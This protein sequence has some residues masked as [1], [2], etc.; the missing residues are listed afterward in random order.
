MN[1]P[2]M[3]TNC[4]TE[5]TLAAF[6]DGRLDGKARRRVV[7]HVA[8]CGECRDVILAAGELRVFEAPS[9]VIFAWRRTGKVGAVAALAAAAVLVVL[10]GPL[11]RER[12]FPT[13][14]VDELVAAA[15]ELDFRPLEG[16]MSGEVAYK[17]YKAPTRGN[18]KHQDQWSLEAVAGR[19]RLREEHHKNVETIRAVGVAH[20]L[21]KEHDDA[22]QKLEEALHEATHERITLVAIR[23]TDNWQLLNDLGVAYMER[24]AFRG[25]AR[26]RLA[27]IEILERA[28]RL[29][30]G[31]EIA[32]N[33]ALALERAGFHDR[34][35]AAWNEYLRLDPASQWSVDAK[36]HIQNLTESSS[37]RYSRDELLI[38]IR[39]AVRKR[40]RNQLQSLADLYPEQFR[41]ISEEVLI[42]EAAALLPL[43][44]DAL[45][46]A[47]DTAAVLDQRGESLPAD[48]LKCL[49]RAGAESIRTG[50]RALEEYRQGRERMQRGE[51]ATAYEL[52]NGATEHLLEVRNPFAVRAAVFR[53][54]VRLYDGHGREA[55]ALTERALQTPQL[56]RWPLAAAQLYWVRGL[57]LHGAGDPG[58]AIRSY[59]E[60]SRLI[61]QTA[62]KGSR[63]GIE[64]VLADALRDVG[65]SDE[66]WRHHM[67]AVAALDQTV[68]LERKQNVLNGFV[69]AAAREGYRFLP[70]LVHEDVVSLARRVGDPLFLCSSQL[71]GAQLA[72]EMLDIPA[73]E[74][75]L[76]EAQMA[77]DR[78][79]ESGMRK[80]LLADL[81]TAR[82][83][84]M[85]AAGREPDAQALSQSLALVSG[86]DN[87]TRLAELHL[88][89]A[90]SF[91]RAGA[92]NEARSDFHA[93]LEELDAQRD[94][95][96]EDDK[97]TQA[98]LAK[99]LVD[100]WVLL[101]IQSGDAETAFD[102][103]E[104]FRARLLLERI[105]GSR[106]DLRGA[107]PW[108]VIRQRLA[109]DTILI[110]YSLMR[111]RL[112]IWRGTQEGLVVTETKIDSF[113]FRAD[114]ER[115]FQALRRPAPLYGAPSRKLYDL[116]C[117]D[118]L[119]GVRARTVVFV[120]DS[121]MFDV[122]FA[123]LQDERSGRYVIED[124]SLAI[125]PSATLAVLR[126]DRVSRPLA[127]SLIVAVSQ[128]TGA[129]LLPAVR[130]EA[131]SVAAHITNPILLIDS[132]A[133]VDAFQ[134]LAISSQLIHF[135]GHGF[136]DSESP[137]LS[138]LRFT[139][140]DGE[141]RVL[142]ASEIAAMKLDH[143]RLV[144]LAACKTAEGRS[145]AE[146]PLT[147]STAFM[148]AG[149]PTVVAATM[150]VD[151]R[152]SSLLFARFYVRYGEGDSAADSL[153]DAQLI[154][155]RDPRFLAP[156]Y[157]APYTVIGMP[158]HA[159]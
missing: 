54:T 11:L 108:R 92:T 95:L 74:R 111:D 109:K 134:R 25:V 122:P 131:Q 60:A 150:D 49:E 146:T 152:A 10:F 104:S 3:M 70:S 14:G 125:A 65:E 19:V 157:W 33:R 119:T 103:A 93:G 52:L 75:S 140:K 107:S 101:E 102:V 127:S 6:I 71:I 56:V 32:W 81:E 126:E 79:P 27:A 42:P 43:R 129:G 16:R 158:A 143:V 155:M 38:A 22:V 21:L 28:W 24:G 139:S 9:D 135:A 80:R 105:A 94:T 91:Q 8:E 45:D 112:V 20:L 90:K 132:E 36:T 147:L 41:L 37:R 100:G 63:A 58:G 118:A 113:D 156:R 117:R 84:L 67:N 26:D 47:R 29:H 23:Q 55:I 153:R 1:D 159:G 83:R 138:G 40:D 39:G 137:A 149:V 96:T 51:H 77:W 85:A 62:E 15:H 87:H 5:E 123:A 57:A 120:P 7:E 88:L 97:R 141:E 48:T 61:G 68:S 154:L 59:G 124:Y 69:R 64:L 66:A 13:N 76:K 4:P 148:A 106:S 133:T 116:L 53:A 2:A 46:I 82:F 114:L 99:E 73:A 110:A 30:K 50:A 86:L 89:R 17:P 12:F 78:L 128:S 44:G 142:T 72:V 35:L 145:P 18:E 144:V 136:V 121:D 34:A 130:A 98:T 151:D 31:N 115:L